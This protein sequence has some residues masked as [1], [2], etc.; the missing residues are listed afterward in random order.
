MNLNGKTI[1]ILVAYTQNKRIIGAQGNIPW[2]ISTERNRFKQICNNKY[3]LMGRKS[4]E[5]IGKALPYCKI[6]VISKTL[7]EVPEGCYLARGIKEAVN[8]IE[9]NQTKEDS[10]T[11]REIL[12]AGGEEI[13]KQTLPYASKIYATEI[14]LNIDGDRFFPQLDNNWKL[15]ESENHCENN[16]NYKYLTFVKI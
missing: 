15:T 16:I 14:A 2:K 7:K 4:F 9:K 3:I 13:Y 1:S 5:E 12:I 10:E 11:S 6:I 8:F